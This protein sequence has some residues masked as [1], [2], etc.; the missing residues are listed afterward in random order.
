MLNPINQI[1]NTIG[2]GIGMTEN[3]RLLVTTF[4]IVLH[5]MSND[6]VELVNVNKV[7]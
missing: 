6:V 7:I 5:I 4:L 3:P 2:L 1:S